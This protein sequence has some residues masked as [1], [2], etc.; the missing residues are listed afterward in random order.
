MVLRVIDDGKGMMTHTCIMFVVAAAAA[1][2]A[3]EADDADDTDD[4]HH[5]MA[6]GL[7]DRDVILEGLSLLTSGPPSFA[8]VPAEHPALI[9][10]PGQQIWLQR[11]CQRLMPWR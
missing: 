1:D 10:T 6:V 8:G 4:C 9:S 3:D 2:E 11:L 7:L 5:M